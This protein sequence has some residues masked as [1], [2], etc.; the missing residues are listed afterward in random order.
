MESTHSSDYALSAYSNTEL[1][2]YFCYLQVHMED[3]RDNRGKRHNLAFVLCG[4]FLAILCGKVLPAGIAR[5]LAR[6]HGLLCDLL[7]FK[8]PKAISDP[9]LRRVLNGLD[10]QTLSL[11]HDKYFSWSLILASCST[12][13][14]G[15]SWY[16]FDGKDLRGTIDGVLG[17]KRDLS[18]VRAVSQDDSLSIGT[19]FYQ[20][21]KDSEIMIVRQLLEDKHL[22][23][24]CVTFDALHCQVETLEMVQDAKG[25]YIVQ[26]KGNQAIL[27]EDMLATIQLGKPTA[28]H[29]AHDKGHGRI[30]SREALFFSTQGVVFEDK[31]QKAGFQQIIL[32]KRKTIHQKSGKISEEECLFISNSNRHSS[33]ELFQRIR[34]HW[35]IEA[36]NWV[37]DVTLREDK[38]RTKNNEM[39]QVLAVYITASLSL[40]RQQ[41]HKNIKKSIEDYQADPRLAAMIVKNKFL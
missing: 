11:F 41:K 2:T 16:S 30:E 17:E 6:H 12:E 8:A 27:Q 24:S 15:A 26:V 38:I 22:A 7:A 35:A 19:V 28:R 33:L 14:L 31:W 32:L 37:R 13:N 36:D 20:G 34:K 29:Q 5:F 39:M 4:V 18:L 23:S 25:V 21:N 9:Q 40:M 3:K 1:R 10:S